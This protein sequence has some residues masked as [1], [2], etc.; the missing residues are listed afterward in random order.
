MVAFPIDSILAVIASALAILFWL[1]RIKRQ[2]NE[3]HNGSLKEY[4]KF[5]FKKKINNK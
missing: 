2:I 5:I 1:P 4:I 3:Y